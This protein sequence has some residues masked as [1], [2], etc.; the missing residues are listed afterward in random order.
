MPVV[1]DIDDVGWPA[2]LV[3]ARFLAAADEGDRAAIGVALSRLLAV[4]LNVDLA[5]LFAASRR[6]AP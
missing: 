2:A 3:A 4:L 1:V 5:D 6:D